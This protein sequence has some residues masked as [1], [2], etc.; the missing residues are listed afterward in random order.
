[1]LWLGKMAKLLFI[2]L[3]FLDLLYKEEVQESIT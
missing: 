3:S 1:M 2:Y